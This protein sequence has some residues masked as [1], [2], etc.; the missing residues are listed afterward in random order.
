MTSI[1]LRPS[2]LRRL[3]FLIAIALVLAIVAIFWLER[4]SEGAKCEKAG[5]V[6]VQ[7]ATGPGAFCVRKI[8]ALPVVV[9]KVKTT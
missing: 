7:S 3:P 5:G 4:W 9:P 8:E 1:E 2:P 6:Y